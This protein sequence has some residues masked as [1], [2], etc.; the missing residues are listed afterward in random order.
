MTTYTFTVKVTD[1]KGQTDTL[2]DSI[3]V[4]SFSL[5][6][7][8]GGGGFS[9]VEFN[10]VTYSYAV[11]AE[12]TSGGYF[13]SRPFMMNGDVIIHHRID[14][15]DS[16]AIVAYRDDGAGGFT[17]RDTLTHAGT[18]TI[19]S[20]AKLSETRLVAFIHDSVGPTHAAELYSY[21]GSAFVLADS[22]GLLEENGKPGY[23]SSCTHDGDAVFVPSYGGAADRFIVIRN[24]S[25]VLSVVYS[26]ITPSTFTSDVCSAGDVIVLSKGTMYTYDG[27]DMTLVQATAGATDGCAY[28]GTRVALIDF[29]DADTYRITEAP[30]TASALG[31]DYE[32]VPGAAN[33]FVFVPTSIGFGYTAS[34]GGIL[35]WNGV[36]YLRVSDFS[37]ESWPALGDI[38]NMVAT[39]VN[40][41]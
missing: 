26:T 1:A 15:A 20:I 36:T 25:D 41:P 35:K 24:T 16:R 22:L 39:V 27:A 12:D 6:V 14:G 4:T 3:T 19:R 32:S 5:V 8:Q 13:D 11:T 7:L 10:P 34:D 30:Y 21:N 38:N 23:L 17:E 9:L 31:F 33:G 37:I 29:G 28:D 18:R 40:T 2:A